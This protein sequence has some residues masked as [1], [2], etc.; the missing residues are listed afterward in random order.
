MAQKAISSA[1]NF[2]VF[3][4]RSTG[5]RVDGIV[6]GY[7]A[8]SSNALDTLEHALRVSYCRL[9]CYKEAQMRK[10]V[11]A[12]SGRRC[13]VLVSQSVSLMSAFLYCVRL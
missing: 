13:R 4:K 10:V 6:V 3:S 5:G 8:L 9:W 11:C 12:E 7:E 2:R 1:L